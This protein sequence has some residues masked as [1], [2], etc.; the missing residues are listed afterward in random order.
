MMNWARIQMK[1]WMAS[2]N[3]HKA[4]AQRRWDNMGKMH[5]AFQRWRIIRV[6][7][8]H[9]AQARRKEDGEGEREKER[10][11]GMEHWGR[12]L[13][14]YYRPGVKVK[15]QNGIDI[16]ILYKPRTTSYRRASDA[17]R[18]HIPSPDPC[19]SCVG[20]SASRP[21][22]PSS[23]WRR[24]TRPSIS[25]GRWSPSSWP[26]SH[27]PS[28]TSPHQSS[29]RLRSSSVSHG[30]HCGLRNNLHNRSR[31]ADTMGLFAQEQG[32][33]RSVKQRVEDDVVDAFVAVESER[34]CTMCRGRSAPQ[35]V[36]H[37]DRSERE[38]RLKLHVRRVC[39][40]G[41]V[42]SLGSVENVETDDPISVDRLLT[43]LGK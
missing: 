9:D 26:R 3:E 24:S 6:G 43:K 39:H 5:K 19:R 22:V 41:S 13:D 23:P 32:V 11:Y 8:E 30:L 40:E 36:R 4:S 35:R 2:I 38:G 28:S 31:F 16:W 42:A 37:G 29:R 33:A 1:T 27:T 20:A 17:R 10:T 12:V 25:T 14:D 18:R 15:P 21:I 34:G 7:H